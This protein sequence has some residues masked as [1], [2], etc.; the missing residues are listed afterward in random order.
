MSSIS[1]YI[2]SRVK[3]DRETSIW[4]RV[5]HMGST[6]RLSTGIKIPAKYWNSKRGGFKDIP[7]ESEALKKRVSLL[8][9]HMQDLKQHLY[10]YI[11]DYSSINSFLIKQE[12]KHFSASKKRQG[13]VAPRLTLSQYID[14]KIGAM[15]QRHFLNR[16][17]PYSKNAID[18]WKK[19]L[20]LWQNFE[21]QQ[22]R[23]ELSP[24]D[25]NMNIY[26]SFMDYCDSINYKRSTKYQYAR[27]FKAALNYALLDGISSNRVHLNRNFAT[28]ASV[29]A[30]KGIYLTMKE[31]F[32]LASL[33]LEQGSTYS[34]IRDLFLLGCYTGLRFSDYH[35]IKEEN[36]IELIIDD[37]KFSALM[38]TQK[39]TKQD[40]TV[41]LFN[42]DILSILKKY[43]GRAPKVSIS[44]F[45]REIKNIC[46]MAGITQ[47]VKIKEIV[48]GRESCKWTTKD[49]LVS[50]HT[51]R[52][53]C[54]TNLYLSGKLDTAQIRDISG[55][56][57]EQAFQR[58]LC[59]SSEENAKAILKRFA[60]QSTRDVI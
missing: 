50:S 26:Y 15:E 45:N 49:R 23:R 33:H 22:N 30:S 31:I 4:I 14:W 34:K 54:I 20:H 10:M 44:S 36:I 38:I 1:F 24:D 13:D 28:H 35:T 41:P 46:R 3:G 47:K 53:T 32:N 40:V 25:I 57:S 9:G 16:G 55:H 43:G 56:R 6:V 21:S 42:N 37:E 58:Y 52:R 11:F 19:F 60:Q 51:A 39:K 2:R 29:E 7:Y 17:E 5:C 59:L 18:N 27:I 8:H 48:G 12:I